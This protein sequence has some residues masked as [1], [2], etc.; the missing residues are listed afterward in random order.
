M[1]KKILALCAAASLALGLTAGCGGP[2]GEDPAAYV[3]PE[4]YR[5]EPVGE[6]GYRAL[7]R[8]AF[9]GL[10]SYSYGVSSAGRDG[11]NS[12]GFDG[13]NWLYIDGN[14][15]HVICEAWGKGVVNKVWTTGTY[16]EQAIVKIYVDDETE[17]VY[18][19]YY[20]NF[21]KGTVKP[22]LYPVTKFWNQSAGGR[23]TYLPMEFSRYVKI[24][25]E[26]PGNTNLFWYVDYS[27]LEDGC[28]VTP[29]TGTEDTAQLHRLWEG[30]GLDFKS[31][32]G[33]VR[34]QAEHR[35]APGESHTY[36]TAQ[37]PRQLQSI[38]ITVPG[39]ELPATAGDAEAGLKSENLRETLNGLR[40]KIRW[41]GEETPSVDC[42]LAGFFGIGSFGYNN[43]VSGLFYGVEGGTLY[44]YF[45]MP[46]QR[47]AE[48]AV[49]NTSGE[50]VDLS[51]EVRSKPVD[52]DFYN[53]GY[54]KTCEKDVYVNAA[55]PLE[56]CLLSETGSGKV[57]SLQLNCFG[58]P[59]CGVQYEEGDVRV[60][61]DGS[62]TPQIVSPGMEDFFNGAGYFIDGSSRASHGL[63]TT[64]LSG[65][66]NW[67]AGADGAE[68][69]SVYRV[70]AADAMVFRDGISFCI[71][72]GGGDR[73]PEAAGWHRN[74]SAGYESLIC[75]YH[76]PVR[77]MEQTDGFATADEAQR[78][79]HAFAAEGGTQAVQVTSG[80]AGGFDLV[81]R[82]MDG[83]AHRDG[84]SFTLA[85]DPDNHGAVLS[86]IFDYG[87]PNCGASV[88]V[89]GEYAGYWCRAGY[90]D[91]YRLCEDRLILP[92]ALTQGKASVTIR[93]R[94]ENGCTWNA[95][96]YAV[97]CIVDRA[98]EKRAPAWGD[99][100]NL[101][102]GDAALTV[103]DG[104][105]AMLPVDGE[106]RSDFRLARYEDGTWFLL[107]S[108]DGSVLAVLDGEPAAAQVT[109]ERLDGRYRW[110]LEETGGGFR[111]RNLADGRCLTAQGGLSDGGDKL[112][113]RP[114]AERRLNRF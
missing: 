55:D 102:A 35:L 10:D 98:A 31:G 110:V 78:G 66:T 62:R 111:V 60:Y 17:P 14:G 51:V 107:N 101:A 21:T 42:S 113:L 11:G 99:V 69:I 92:A 80:F 3:R 13:R 15:D 6:A 82:T 8:M 91:V 20:Y 7:D 18:S 27:L 19:D 75:Y 73:D 25:I 47:S 26:E 36:F 87:T 65:Y 2:E 1:K 103:Q 68:G 67:H 53:V 58:D 37:G 61:I 28:E 16:N 64:Q 74:Q 29:F 71:E 22:F 114:V 79:A 48:L 46:F 70:F 9:I 93:I 57:V 83:I 54:F 32:A 105:C 109:T 86:R 104:R 49:E 43:S 106:G 95:M 88:Y 112:D 38:K 81:E 40:L 97:R 76:T 52:Y 100:V 41:D 89:D 5:S 12:D 30:T 77:R 96:E 84:V 90:N 72:H 44:N 94:P 108:F 23:V 39:L 24:A 85:L 45:P 59:G 33:V 56:L 63:Y 4:S 34:E 50:A